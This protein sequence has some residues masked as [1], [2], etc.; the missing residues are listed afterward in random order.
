MSG[1]LNMY[2][3]VRAICEADSRFDRAAYFFVFDALDHTLEKDGRKGHISPQRLLEGVKS[4]ARE[5]FGYLAFTVFDCWGVRSTE[6]FGEIV[7]NLVDH[8]LMKKTE[9]DRKEDFADQYDFERVFERE[10]ELTRE[11]LDY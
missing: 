10:F 5:K 11:E 4:Y 2:E 1:Q 8:D 9:S 6:D 7:F 3:G